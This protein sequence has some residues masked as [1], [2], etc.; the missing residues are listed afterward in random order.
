MMKFYYQPENTWFGDC[1][2]YYHNGQFYLYHQRDTRNPGP[3]FDSEPFGWALAVTDDFVD[4]Q[5]MGEVL[6]R[7]G[8]E[9]QDQF[10]FAGSLFGAN[11]TYYALYTGFNRNY[12]GTEKPSQV[13]MQAESKDLLNWKKTGKKLVAPEQGYDPNEWRDPWVI[14]DEENNRYL[15]LIGTR[16]ITSGQKKTGCIV[17]YT[18]TDMDNWEF[19]GDFWAPELYYVQE[20]PEIFRWGDWW[21][22]VFTEY[23]D[24]SKTRYRMSRSIEGPWVSPPFDDAFDGRAY[25]AARSCSDGERRY[26]FGWVPTREDETDDKS[27]W[28]WGGTLVV[29]EVLQI[30]DGSLRVKPVDALSK[31]C[32]EAKQKLAG[33]NTKIT[34]K[35]G[36]TSVTVKSGTSDNFCVKAKIKTEGTPRE[37]YLR[38]FEES[39][40]GEAYEFRLSAENNRLSFDKVP[41]LPWYQFDNRGI[42]RP[43]NFT[44]GM[45]LDITLFVDDTIATVYVNGVA[46]NTRMYNKAGRDLCIG[47]ADGSM[48]ILDICYMEAK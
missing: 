16:K 24:T 37:I 18:S 47:L 29:H 9:A 8:E 17:Y 5:D 43:F 21:Y 40:T 48:E 7:G 33:F 6:Q 27:P 46:L 28:V 4:Y 20:M 30:L 41:A 13:L 44:S 22:I 12:I 3:L 42:E 36:A 35:D 23:S 19:Q 14:W 25:Y 31:K 32:F 38:L 45:E 15:M 1:M 34:R 11:D 39:T 10:I 2:P 26:L